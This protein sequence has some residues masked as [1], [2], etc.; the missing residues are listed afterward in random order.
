MKVSEKD[1]IKS[2]KSSKNISQALTKCGLVAKGG[3]YAR[4][5]RLIK[6]NNLS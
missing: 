6:E 5:R 4:V 1:L 3:N 2:I